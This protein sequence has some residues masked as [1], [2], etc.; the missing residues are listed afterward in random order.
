[1]CTLFKCVDVYT[2]ECNINVSECVCVRGCVCVGGCA[3][4]GPG[5]PVGG[6][7]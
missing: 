4:R 6:Q 1:M 7:Q 5:R 3:M 2:C